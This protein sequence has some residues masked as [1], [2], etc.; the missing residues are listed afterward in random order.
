MVI[1]I[2]YLPAGCG[3]TATTATAAEA[4]SE[5]ASSKAATATAASTDNNGAGIVALLNKRVGA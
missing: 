2:F 5:T 1:I 3:T 4:T